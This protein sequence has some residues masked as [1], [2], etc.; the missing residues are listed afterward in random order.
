MSGDDAVRVLI[1]DDHGMVRDGLRMILESHG[2]EVVG[3]AGDGEAAVRNT[4]AL[5]PDVVLMDLRMPRVD[6]VEATRRIVG[7]DVA[8]V[9][10]LTS[11]DEDDLVFAAIR[12]GAAGFLL[13]TTEAAP[14]VDAVTR[15]ARG[16]GVLDPRVTRR[17][18]AAIAEGPDPAAGAL[19][20]PLPGL[21]QLTDRERQVLAALREGESNARV[22]VRLG[23]SIPTVKTHVSGVLTKLGAESRTQAAALAQGVH[24]DP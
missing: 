7:A 21:A 20:E 1:A 13:K 10:V 5:R 22:A 14:L 11:F 3:E 2:V 6:G 15:V 24:L 8:P 23:I 19:E 12:A 16:E 9:L 17:A 4:E 18:L